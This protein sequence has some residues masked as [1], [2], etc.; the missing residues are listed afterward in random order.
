MLL[1]ALV[2]ADY[3]DTEAWLNPEKHARR[4]RTLSSISDLLKTV[5]KDQEKLIT[6][7]S[8]TDIN[9]A[10]REIY[11][12]VLSKSAGHAVENPHQSRS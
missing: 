11:Y 1:S 7:A 4:E 3:L 9:Q 6:E 10:R 8:H 2:D 12:A 5:I